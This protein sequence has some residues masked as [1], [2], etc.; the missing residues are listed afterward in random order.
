MPMS[1][2]WGYS[3]PERIV[4][5]IDVIARVRACSLIE[6]D[7]EGHGDYEVVHYDDTDGCMAELEESVDFLRCT[8][9]ELVQ[10]ADDLGREV[11]Q[12]VFTSLMLIR[13][14]LRIASDTADLIDRAVAGETDWEV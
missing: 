2:Q 6:M 1:G 9:D 11:A 5:G 8:P 14:E 7:D 13:D 4:D 3:M 10:L 12:Q